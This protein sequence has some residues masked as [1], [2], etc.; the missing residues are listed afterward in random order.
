MRYCGLKVGDL[1]DEMQVIKETLNGHAYAGCVY[2][3]PSGK[4]SMRTL[5]VTQS[6]V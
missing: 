1:S 3:S 4:N 6:F 5:R 2:L